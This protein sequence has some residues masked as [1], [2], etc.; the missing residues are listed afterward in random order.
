MGNL[1]ALKREVLHVARRMSGLGLVANMGGNVSARDPQSNRIVITPSAYA[2]DVMTEND[3]V[4][5][6]LWGKVVSGRHTP[7]SETPVHCLVYRERP[8]VCGIVHTEPPYVNAFGMLDREIP[9][10]LANLL[11]AVGG[12]VPVMPVQA[13]GTEAFGRDMLQVM[14][15]TPA[16]IWSHHGLLTV[17]STLA[18]A[19]ER[20]CFIEDGAKAY[21]L[22]LQLGQ[23]TA[24]S[25]DQFTH[26]VG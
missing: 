19:F 21:H 26:L 22:A 14:G 20:T 3:V 17:G 5:V 24:L 7:S 10:V 2:Y 6:D 18:Q 25:H 23:P 4:E 15:S 1:E 8:A 12:S 16:V 13:S 11:A 9:P